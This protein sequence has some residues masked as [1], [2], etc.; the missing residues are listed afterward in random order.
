MPILDIVVWLSYNCGRLSP[1]NHADYSDLRWTHFDSRIKWFSMKLFQWNFSVKLSCVILM[2]FWWETSVRCYVL[3]TS[4]SSDNSAFP[5]SILFFVF[6]SFVIRSLLT[7]K[8]ILLVD[9]SG[10]I[11]LVLP[12]RASCGPKTFFKY[13]FDSDYLSKWNPTILNFKFAPQQMMFGLRE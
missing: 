4:A 8:V 12:C 7:H 2:Q 6:H 13:Q 3:S 5:V 11:P 1:P 9:T 10:N